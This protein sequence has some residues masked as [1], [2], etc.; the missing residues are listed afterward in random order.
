MARP[1]PD[2]YRGL[3][4]TLQGAVQ[5]GSPAKTDVEKRRKGTQT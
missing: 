4:G 2:A 3:R 1:I 5:A